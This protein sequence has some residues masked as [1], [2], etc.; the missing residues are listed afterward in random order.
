MIG[1]ADQFGQF[2]GQMID[3]RTQQG[4]GSDAASLRSRGLYNS[5]IYDTMM[6]GRD[7][8]AQLAKQALSEQVLGRKHGSMQQRAGVR[9][10]R[11][12]SAGDMGMIA[13]LMQ[14]LGYA[15]GGGGGGRA[16]VPR[17]RNYVPGVTSGI[18]IF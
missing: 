6:R 10:R 12:D 2:E 8:D 16:P 4:K 7:F 14:S 11:T 9:E 15:G 3:R 5:T 17:R 18:G 1:E 13:Q